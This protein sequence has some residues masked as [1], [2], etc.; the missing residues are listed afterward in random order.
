[1][2]LKSFVAYSPGTGSRDLAGEFPDFP[3]TR[4]FSGNSPFS[5]PVPGE[6]PG[7]SYREFPCYVLFPG[8]SPNIPQNSPYERFGNI[9]F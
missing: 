6:F 7:N 4:E 8:N 9:I 2:A 3:K 1:M 5:F